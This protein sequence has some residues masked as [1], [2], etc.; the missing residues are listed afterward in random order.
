MV[1]ICFINLNIKPNFAT[2]FIIMRGKLSM[3]KLFY[4]FIRYLFVICKLFV[5]IWHHLLLG[6]TKCSFYFKK[7]AENFLFFSPRVYKVAY[8]KKE[9]KEVYQ[10]IRLFTEDMVK[11]H[12]G[13]LPPVENKPIILFFHG[14]S[15]NVTKWQETFIFLKK[16]GCGALFLSYRGHYKSAGRPSEDGVY[17]DAI[18]AMNFLF[19]KGYKSED[20]ILWGRSLGS[21]VAIETALKYNVKALILESPIANI[22][23]AAL[24]I[25]SRYIK[26]FKFLILRRFIKWLL[27]SADY[28]QKFANDDKIDKI[29]CPILIMH[30]R[31]D[32]KI[33]YEQSVKL[34]E[35][36]PSA[37]LII[38]E[39]G[40]HDSAEWCYPYVKSFIEGL[41]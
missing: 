18:T 12:A 8:L 25:F 16:L 13:F 22:K 3:R 11:L 30:A 39:E 1:N 38:D 20:I 9:F 19:S 36:N 14:Q 31:N 34:A 41:D 29:K 33:T 6:K 5:L 27:E 26:I 23:E 28:I 35:K 40:S 7:K 4:M 21:A 2:T 32:E 17:T 24:S 15:E 10:P 37:K